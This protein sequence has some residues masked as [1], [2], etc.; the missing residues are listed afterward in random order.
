M[1]ISR[2]SESKLL[3]ESLESR[4]TDGGLTMQVPCLKDKPD[5]RAVAKGHTPEVVGRHR[6]S[7]RIYAQ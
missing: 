2:R 1:T 3:R 5:V 6:S 7:I 4:R